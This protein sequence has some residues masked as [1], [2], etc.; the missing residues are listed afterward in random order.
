[1]SEIDTMIEEMNTFLVQRG[2]PPCTDINQFTSEQW[3][4]FS[5]IAL[6]QYR[7]LALWDL[8]KQLGIDTANR[9]TI[10]R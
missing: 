6:N 9:S 10:M 8:F 3:F 4:D 7:N 5:Q 1:M 2:Y